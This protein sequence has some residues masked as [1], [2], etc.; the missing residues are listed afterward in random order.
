MLKKW[1]VTAFNWLNFVTWERERTHFLYLAIFH[2]R[3]CVFWNTFLAFITKPQI[4][5]IWIT[6]TDN[7]WLFHSVLWAI[8]KNQNSSVTTLLQQSKDSR[9]WESNFHAKEKVSIALRNWLLN[10]D[11]RCFELHPGLYFSSV[12][13]RKAFVW[14]QFLYFPSIF[15]SDAANNCQRTSV[16]L[17]VTIYYT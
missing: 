6:L 7:L 13:L 11:I 2:A 14:F 1:L 17:L 12:H 5:I 4:A 10:T 15:K 3:G 8:K 9:G 16:N